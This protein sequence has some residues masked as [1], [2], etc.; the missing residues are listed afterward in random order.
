[1]GAHSGI[2]D[3]SK[4]HP[5]RS[6]YSIL[7]YVKQG[8]EDAESQLETEPGAPDE[9]PEDDQDGQPDPPRLDLEPPLTRWAVV[10]REAGHCARSS[11]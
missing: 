4:I 9:A 7:L 6:K 2:L 1:M 5:P 8:P 10:F 3:P 11:R